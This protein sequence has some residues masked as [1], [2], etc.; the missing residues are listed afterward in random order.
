MANSYSKSN[1]ALIGVGTGTASL[2]AEGGDLVF[3]AKESA[4]QVV[5]YFYG[6]FGKTVGAGAAI[7]RPGLAKVRRLIVV[8]P[9]NDPFL[10]SLRRD[11]PDVVWVKTW[12]E[13]LSLLTTQWG[14]QA[15]VAVYPDAT[16]QYFPEGPAPAP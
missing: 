6:S 11:I 9:S 3:I 8:M 15:R 16:I 2:W 13:C 1:E 12:Q 10:L 5:H 4:G 7:A 14:G